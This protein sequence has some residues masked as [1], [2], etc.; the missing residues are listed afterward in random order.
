VSLSHPFGATQ[1][2]RHGWTTWSPTAWR[3]LAGPP[4]RGPS[5]EESPATANDI[6]QQSPPRHRGSGVG[7][8]DGPD[9]NV[10]LLGALGLGV[11]TV[12]SDE[13]TLNGW[14][15]DLAVPWFLAYG[16]ED[17]VFAR[18]AD[19]L[20]DHLGCRHQRAGNVWC[21]WYSYFEDITERLIRDA[22]EGLR[23]LPFD[24]VQVDDGWQPCVG[25]WQAGP[26]VP[27]GMAMLAEQIA[28]GEFRPGLWLAPFI[29]SGRSRIFHDRRHLFLRDSDGGPIAAGHNWGAPFYAL[30]TTLPETID[31]IVDM[32][33]RV[34]GWGYD[35]FKLDFMYAGALASSRARD[36]PREQAY[37]AAVACI[38][39]VVGEETYLLGCGAP[40]IPSIGLFDGV[41][42]GPDTAPYW[43][44]SARADDYSGPG[45]RNALVTSL[46][47][48]WLRDAFEIDPDVAFFRTRYNLLD[49]SCRRYLTDLANVCDFRAT[50]DPIEWLDA[51]ER[52]ALA[53][54]L[55]HRPRVKRT[56]RYVF[57]IDEREVD[58]WPAIA[59]ERRVSDRVL[60]K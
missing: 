21:S 44:N 58:F 51:N 37:R 25:D 40:L 47:R 34:K 18:Y 23:G 46:H 53:E 13:R 60:S 56:G 39:E 38:R 29:A 4:L 59:P 16:P 36:L 26:D 43:Y 31:H 50:S 52:A 15:E 8:L 22:V 55:H 5:V 57:S 17:V 9:G 24:V 33:Q 10:L 6:V 35:Y 19:L 2:Y 12:E 45:A 30:D 42:I 1:F 28:E 3:P 54:F 14:F 11:P 20:T 49:D 32:F 27:S 48:L 41:R 7:A